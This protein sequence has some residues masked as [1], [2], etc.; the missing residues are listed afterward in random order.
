M[1]RGHVTTTVWRPR[2]S[3]SSSPI[4]RDAEVLP[5]R[6]EVIASE[7]DPVELVRHRHVD[8]RR[9]VR[10]DVVE[11]EPQLVGVERCVNVQIGLPVVQA[12]SPM[13]RCSSTRMP[14]R[15]RNARCSA[16]LA[17]WIRRVWSVHSLRRGN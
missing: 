1:F 2:R 11:V 17:S 8:E 14:S 6:L 3:T 5:N 7:A 13:C 4:F 10:R 12:G 16:A 15:G 9:V